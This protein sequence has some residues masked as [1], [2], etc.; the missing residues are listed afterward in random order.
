VFL[1]KVVVLGYDANMV[2]SG[3]SVRHAVGCAL[4][5]NDKVLMQK[6]DD[7]PNIFGP[8]HWGLPGGTVEDGET[9]ESAVVREFQEETGY[10]LKNPL[11][12]GKYVFSPKGQKT[13]AYIFYEVYDGEQ[14]I[15]CFEGEKMEFK[16]LREM[17]SLKVLPKHTELAKLAIERAQS[18]GV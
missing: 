7:I 6:R 16:S 9:F 8:G 3:K 11:L 12:L 2:E 13:I 15:S 4:V 14:K 17:D 10:L 1:S 18:D 5:K